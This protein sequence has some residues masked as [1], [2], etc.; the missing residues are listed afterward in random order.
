MKKKLKKQKELS[1]SQ[2]AD[3]EDLR[4]QLD[5]LQRQASLKVKTVQEAS[6]KKMRELENTLTK[7]Y[8]NL[9]S[10]DQQVKEL[11]QMKLDLEEDI[12]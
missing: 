11:T 8:N 9:R 6:D 2:A 10:L 12:R 3:L 4:Q 1:E 5:G 7:A